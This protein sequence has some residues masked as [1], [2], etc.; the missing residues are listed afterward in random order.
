MLKEKLS[1]EELKQWNDAVQ[2]FKESKKEFHNNFNN[3]DIHK[4]INILVYKLLPCMSTYWKLYEKRNR[5]NN[6]FETIHDQT[7]L[8][9]KSMMHF[10]DYGNIRIQ[11]QWINF[12]DNRII[13]GGE[14][15]PFYYPQYLR[16]MLN[17]IIEDFKIEDPD[18]NECMLFDDKLN[19][20]TF[21]G[22]IF[23]KIEA[24]FLIVRYYSANLFFKHYEIRLEFTRRFKIVAD[25]V[26]QSAK[27]SLKYGWFSAIAFICSLS[28]FFITVFPIIDFLKF[29]TN[30]V[31]NEWLKYIIW[32][33]VKMP[34]VLF[35]WIGIKC[36]GIFS[37]YDKERR[38]LLML[39]SY[40]EKLF[41]NNKQDD[42]LIALAP[43]YFGTKRNR[44]SD[45]N[46]MEKLLLKMIPTLNINAGGGSN[47]GNNGGQND[48]KTD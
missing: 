3:Q 18:G 45:N 20:D 4:C 42:L 33:T 6:F 13:P 12:G 5:K 31:N 35:C 34:S 2:K 8:T 24:C 30:D 38:E 23:D 15:S 36:F 16:S 7:K 37:I 11:N 21:V 40:K 41:D 14:D 44:R 43:N 32:I 9:P 17:H 1:K 27:Q 39:D 47:N 48:G 22:K 19:I 29:P 10:A 28:W 26:N 46:F 25:M